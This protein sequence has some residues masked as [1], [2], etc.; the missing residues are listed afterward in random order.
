MTYLQTLPNILQQLSWLGN[1]LFFFLAFFES[2]PFVGLFLPG[3]TLISAGG[4][5]ASQGYLNVWDLI[6]CAATGAIAGDFLSYFLGRWGSD[7]LK[8]KKIINYK[9]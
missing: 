2:A 1:W 5:L 7:R 8:N 9:N 6:F 4:F 3:A